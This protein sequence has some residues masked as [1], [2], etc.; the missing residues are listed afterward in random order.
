MS[1]RR[2]P[3]AAQ[4]YIGLSATLGLFIIG[5]DLATERL[6]DPLVFW[7][8]IGL[9]VVANLPRVNLTVKN[10]YMTLSNTVV[11]LAILLLNGTLPTV[12]VALVSGLVGTVLVKRGHDAEG[13]PKPLT[14]YKPALTMANH[15]QAGFAAAW[16]WNWLWIGHATRRDPSVMVLGLILITAT[17][18]VVNTTGISL[19]VALSGKLPLFKVWRENFLWTFAGYLCAACFAMAAVLCYTSSSPW[20]Q[21]IAFLALAP[22]WMVH[23]FYRM[24]MDKLET[25]SRHGLELNE[26]NE[27]MISTLAMSIEAKDRYTHKHVERVREYANAIAEELAISEPE[28]KAVR[29]GAMVHDIGKIGVPEMILTKPGK[30]TAEEFD[31]MK[32]HVMVGV[33]ILEAVRFPFP[34]TDA[35]AAHHEHWDGNGYPLGLKGEAIPLVGRIVSLADGFDALT[36]DRPYRKRMSNEE[37]LALLQSQKGEYYDP[38]VVDAM[39]RVLPKVQ[40]II[41]ELNRAEEQVQAD[42]QGAV[43]TISPEAL[44]EIA[45]AAEEAFVLAELSLRPGRPSSRAALLELLLEKAAFMIPSTAAA[46]FLVD[47]RTQEVRV[48]RCA[49][50]YSHLLED[51]TMKV[52][53]GVSGWVV[54]QNKAIA[55]VPAAG[56]VARRVEPGQNVELNTALSVPLKSGAECIGAITLYHTGYNIYNPHYQRLLS[57]L[58]EHASGA[59]EAMNQMETDHAHSYTD[60]LTDLP[61][62]RRIIRH[63][64]KLTADPR[65]A[66][67]I[68]LLDLNDFKRLNDT[69]GHRE[70]DQ[71]LRDIA[72]LLRSSARTEELVGRYA[73]DE[74]VIVCHSRN[75]E[76]AQRVASRI[77]GGLAHYRFAPNEEESIS[78]SI[79][80]ASY[81]E[82]GTDWR[83]I[84]SAADRRMY[85]EKLAYQQIRATGATLVGTAIPQTT[86]GP[87]ENHATEPG[88]LPLP[89]APQRRNTDSSA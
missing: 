74:F 38:K 17:Y 8:L 82:D 31:R 75:P 43:P 33:R 41:D 3:L 26:L 15:V 23:Q 50:L 2:L 84:L 25:A 63:M 80:V 54:Q 89:D 62:M 66:F 13:R 28:R 81:P 46:V 32:S 69:Y 72:K 11:F 56:D 68:L 7:A 24:N 65:G 22:A 30:L 48:E 49:G 52:G 60:S 19:A 76:D 73:G 14:W 85:R 1:F 88:R 59:L 4:I 51:L 39:V 29:I 35:V 71:I 37:A 20:L 5:L 6:E 83:S 10:A 79:G 70:G 45:R 44:E 27:R 21:L 9:A 34:V 40:V 67:Q 78:T 55:N 18:Y 47:S 61:N 16:V 36:T 77:K 58:A 87:S 86:L 53:E 42:H 12:I 57:T 64:E